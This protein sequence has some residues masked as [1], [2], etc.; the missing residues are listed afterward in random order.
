MSEQVVTVIRKRIELPF[1]DKT[2][3]RKRDKGYAF[4]KDE[5]KRTETAHYQYWSV[6]VNLMF[7]KTIRADSL[8][9]ALGLAQ[10]EYPGARVFV[11]PDPIL[12]VSVRREEE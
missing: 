7:I 2:S 11:E 1:Q 9:H 4:M 8:D 6:F 12:N 10:R 5:G 3:Q